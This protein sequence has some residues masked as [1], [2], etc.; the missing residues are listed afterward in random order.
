MRRALL[1][2][3][4]VLITACAPAA[5]EP[6]VPVAKPEPP[7]P[8]PPKAE[9]PHATWLFADTLS[10]AVAQLDLGDT[11]LQVGGRGRRWKLGKDAIESSP[12]LF[13]QT[14]IDVRREGKQFLFLGIDGT[15]YLTDD[16]LGPSKVIHRTPT[17]KAI[18]AM[19]KS[20]IFG[21]GDDGTLYRSTNAGES[22]QKSKSPMAPG[23]VVAGLVANAR[24]EALL[25]VHPQRVFLSIDDGASFTPLATPGIGAAGLA[26]DADNDL[27]LTGTLTE[28]RAKLTGSPARLEITTD[29]AELKKLEAKAPP[30]KSK[31]APRRSLAGD[32]VVTINEEIDP[33]SKRKKIE[34]SV[35]P[36]GGELGQPYVLVPSA[37]PFIKVRVEGYANN[38]V[39]SYDDPQL[40]P[41]AVHFVR[42]TDDG[43]TWDQLGALEGADGIGFGLLVGPGWLAVPELCGPTPPCAPA[44]LKVGLKDW[45]ALGVAQG[46]RPLSA[47]FDLKNDR[48]FIV[49]SDLTGIGVYAGKKDGPFK[50]LAVSVPLGKTPPVASTVDKDGVLRLVFS[51]QYDIVKVAADGKGKSSYLPFRPDGISLAGDRAYAWK[52]DQAWESA[53]AG[54]TWAKVAAGSTGYAECGPTGCL[55]GSSVRVGW[56]LPDPQKPLIAS[57]AQPADS[58]DPAPSKTKP[59]PLPIACKTTGPAQSFE[60]SFDTNHSA[61]DG[62]VR[63]VA[64]QADS[65]PGSYISV[66]RGAAAPKK[67][68]LLGKPPTGK[69]LSVRTWSSSNALGHVG[70][71]YSFS[72]VV[73]TDADGA[74]KYNPVDVELGWYNAV[75]G[76]SHKASIPKVKPF[77][78]GSSGPSALTS[79]VEG[80]LLFLTGRGEAPLYFVREDGKVEALTRPTGVDD[81]GFTEGYK[82]GNQI[83][84]TQQRVEEVAMIGSTDGGKTWTS[85]V[86]SLGSPSTL[87]VFDGKPSLILGV[88]LFGGEMAGAIPLDSVTNDPPAALR[89]LK[90]PAPVTDKG[91]NACAKQTGV[92]FHL[93]GDMPRE[94]K[95]TVS[96]DEA[97]LEIDSVA[98]TMRLQTDGSTCVD[99]I[100]G[101]TY[102]D[103]A[104]RERY[105]VFTPRDPTHGWLVT[106]KG[107][108]GKLEARPIACTF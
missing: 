83:L 60:G 35:G 97:G 66:A 41:R 46:A 47:H 78:V 55:Q 13:A 84:L 101:R 105:V 42:T 45:Q 100:Y 43:K 23:D 30:K 48:A 82:R 70:V 34:V 62:D 89:W 36:I 49:T 79:V 58:N 91:L 67:I 65:T 86:W 73:K 4:V 28:K 95:F 85:A 81:F 72:T 108:G 33:A 50:P 10:P 54:D 57:T 107:W 25:L 106:R 31:S 51:H 77:R 93:E 102:D 99:S 1:S 74:K 98:A 53:D 69:D 38:V 59:A 26:R 64:W 87:D 19:G 88:G 90:T 22:F 40:E 63:F 52:H 15:T 5:P 76:K 94:A 6:V 8:P 37:S 7:K 20:A 3:L 71:R 96:G 68:P 39:V 12:V 103:A 92:R 104:D 18:Y 14:L 16:P 29:F 27:Y 32:R 9:A 11:T 24:G 2:S 21:V 80:G 61:I 44:R 17:E 75:T 56:E